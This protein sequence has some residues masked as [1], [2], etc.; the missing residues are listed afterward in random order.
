MRRKGFVSVIGSLIGLLL[1]FAGILINNFSKIYWIGFPILIIGVIIFIVCL[2]LCIKNGKSKQAPQSISTQEDKIVAVK[3][4]GTRTG[5]ETR[6]LATY[7]FTIYSFL[8]LYE[9]GKRD[10]IE[11]KKDSNEFN[12]L[13]KHIDV[14]N[15]IEETI[16]C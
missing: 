10:V 1:F 11:C 5:K 12:E 14:K 6:V 3:I 8:V 4:L 15:I 9:N 13:I 16:D 2:I 7:N